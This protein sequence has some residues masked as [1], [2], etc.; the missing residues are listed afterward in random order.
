MYYAFHKGDRSI[1]SRLIKRITDEPYSHTELVF[2][3]Y[4]LADGDRIPHYTGNHWDYVC[5]SADGIKNEVRFKVIK[6]SHHER[7]AFMRLYNLNQSAAMDLAIGLDGSPYA[8]GDVVLKEGFG[9][10]YNNAK[11]WYCS[12]VTGYVVGAERYAVSPG[13]QAKAALADGGDWEE[14]YR[15][16]WV[17]K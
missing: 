5:F 1:L 15:L 17:A 11:R 4:A 16:P 12:E 6:F 2:T 8:Y 3:G 14:Y 7:W 10:A 13:K 9:V